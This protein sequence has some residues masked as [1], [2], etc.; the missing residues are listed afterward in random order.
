MA[1]ATRSTSTSPVKK[2]S[3]N[4]AAAPTN[5]QQKPLKH[6]VLPKDI[7]PKARFLLLRHPRDG[8]PQRFLF[9]PERGLFHFNRIS[10]PTTDPR[11]LLFTPCIPE[12]LQTNP[13]E[14]KDETRS[15]HLL[16]KGYISKSP[17]FYV[18][19]PF[20]V[21]FILAPL[22]LPSKPTA[23]KAL[24]QPIDDLFEQRIQDDKELRY[25]FEHGRPVVE[26]AMSMLCDTIEAGG[27]Q[28]YRPSEEK[29]ARMIV[30]KV[31][32]A[33]NRGLPTS[34]LDKFVK[35]ALE[36]PILS[37]KREE[38]LTSTQTVP[39]AMDEDDG[40][41]DSLDSQSSAASTA[42]STIFSEVSTTSSIS[43][44]V[45]EPIS[46]E[47]FELQKQ[48]VV[49]DFILTSYL[50]ESIADRLRARFDSPD[51]PIDF[52]TLKDHLRH[53]EN[54]KAEALAS[55]S[56]TDFS[57]KRGLEDDEALEV[58]AEKKRK[59]EE[60]ER[61]KKLG[62]SR[63]VRELKKVNVSGMKKMSDFFTKKPATTVS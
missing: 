10:A 52:T 35:R 62:E 25:L 13:T 56:I 38:T 27:E 7:S 1:V 12:T 49:L 9:C 58:R 42:Q 26:N 46:K 24:F 17:D 47:L 34:L 33:D 4:A 11:S 44:V 2:P 6:F 45:C 29:T 60:E 63:G 23:A 19:A 40:A 22:I 28:M 59:Q 15:D 41:L 55:R 31:K 3:A 14:P 61:K 20:D 36:A 48:R 57:R 51:S 5:P 16:S 50:P 37:V 18:A 53:L 39:L 54:L 8:N 43:T 30:Q 32:N 21:A